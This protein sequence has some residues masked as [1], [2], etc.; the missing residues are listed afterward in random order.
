MDVR[1]AA[2]GH[3]PYEA[4]AISLGVVTSLKVA[5]L[6]TEL[7]TRIVEAGQPSEGADVAKGIASA[8]AQFSQHMGMAMAV[9]I[10]L[11]VLVFCVVLA[12]LVDKPEVRA[13]CEA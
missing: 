9:G 7:T 5:G 10:G 13:W 8:T 2:W 11:G 1:L 6:Q 4:L 12:R 3:V